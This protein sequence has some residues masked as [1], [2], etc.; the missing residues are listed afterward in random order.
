MLGADQRI[1]RQEAL[2]LATI[3][4]AWLTFEEKIKGS[5]E[6]GKLADFIVLPQD[7]M[8]MPAKAIES[9]NVLHDGRGRQ[10]RL[11]AGRIQAGGVGELTA[12]HKHE[13]IRS[14]QLDGAVRADPDLP[15]AQGPF[16]ALHRG[17]KE[18]TPMH[19]RRAAD[20]RCLISGRFGPRLSR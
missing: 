7:I 13:R 4:N 5:I 18:I 1:T 17:W 12:Q 16:G 11:S 10:G 8:T 19:A 2:R 6:T 15:P 14:F 20:F 3:N 9:M